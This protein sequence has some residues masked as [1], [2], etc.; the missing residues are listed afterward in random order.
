MTPRTFESLKEAYCN[1]ASLVL[2]DETTAGR[3]GRILKNPETVCM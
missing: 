2:K 3:F 1:V